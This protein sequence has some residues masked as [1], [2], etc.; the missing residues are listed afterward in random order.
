[1]ECAI[2]NQQYV[3]KNETPF[4]IRLNNH[5]KDVKDPKA[6]LAGEHFQI[7]GHRFNEHTRFTIIDR[8]TKTNL[9]KEILRER[10][11][12]RESLWLQKLE[13]LYPKGLNQ[14]LNM[15]N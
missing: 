15:Q 14:E 5:R 13:T 7:S 8:F 10:L 4:N 12:Q 6:I 1:M 3:G 11:I 2:C 9:A